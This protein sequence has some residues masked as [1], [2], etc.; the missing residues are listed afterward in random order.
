MDILQLQYFQTI[1]RL[2]NMTKAAEI[3]YVA[4]P[5]LSVS[6]KRLEEDLGVSLFDRRKG[7]IR[8]TAVGRLFL[9]YVDDVLGQLDEAVAQVR[10]ADSHASEQV[11]VAS[12]IVDLIG[13]LLYGF[14]S[15][16]PNVSFRQFNCRN[17]E[18]VG[19]ITNSDADFGFIFGVPQLSGLEY[20][21]IDSCERIV[22][23]AKDHP[24]AERGIVSLKDLSGQRLVCN[25]SRDDAELINELSR[26]RRFRPELFFECDD[27]RVE[28]SMITQGKGL[29]I[30]PLSNYLKLVNEDPGINMTCVRIREELPPARLGMIRK[31]GTHLSQAALQFYEIVHRF[32]LNEKK[33]AQRYAIQLPER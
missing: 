24:L 23:L 19:K 28:V 7:K 20:I 10:E 26:S 16:H 9:S 27:N 17:S 14:L 11:R 12:V 25:L 3:L 5:N 8:L 4:Q 18:V 13:A 15:N 30:A 6:I 31:T 22:Q 2:E 33:I 1:A 32:F 29:S 21:E